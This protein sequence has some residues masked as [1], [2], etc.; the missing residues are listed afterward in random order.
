ML[1]YLFEAT[2]EDGHRIDQPADDR[3]IHHDETLEKNPSA[4]TDVLEYSKKSPLEIFAIVGQDRQVFAVSLKTGEF[5]VNGT[6]FM[7][8]QPLEEL[9]D[10]KIIYHRT[11]RMGLS[12]AGNGEPYTYAYN[13]GYE[14]LTPTG[15]R[16]K[17]VITVR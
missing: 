2:F 14:G 15:K 16:V 3:S 6:T 11:M 10:R 7:L 8:D 4:F 5:F 1:Q 9:T 13:I 17:K 12:D